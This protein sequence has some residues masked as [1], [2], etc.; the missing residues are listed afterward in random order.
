MYSAGEDREIYRSLPMP[1][2]QSQYPSPTKGAF[3]DIDSLAVRDYK[4]GGARSPR[5]LAY[6]FASVAPMS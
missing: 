6:F 4:R 1:R 5:V 2:P 3:A